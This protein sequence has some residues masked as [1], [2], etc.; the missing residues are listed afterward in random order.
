MVVTSATDRSRS[1]VVNAAPTTRWP[2]LRLGQIWDHR[3]LLWF[4]AV[5]DVKVRYKQALL[6]VAWA[7]LQ[8]LI[9]ALTFTVLFHE[10][11]DIELDDG[12][13]FAFALA[14]YSA[15]TYFAT[16]VAA[17]TN[18]LL[19]NAELLTK[20][21]F[22]RI[23]APLSSL[24]PGLIDL[25]VGATLALG[26]AIAGGDGVTPGGL[27]LVLPGLALLLVTAAGP[28]L[29]LSATVVRYRDVSVVVTFGLQLLLF[30]SPVAYP[31]ELVPGSWRTVLYLN[32]VSGSLGLLRAALV[33]SDLPSAA[34]L[35]CSAA[36]AVAL[37]VA[38]LAHFRRNEREFA[39]II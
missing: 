15:W 20:V 5:R 11:A 22:P 29:V 1:W 38:G 35:G 2:A 18:T 26:V 4:F 31:P 28:V 30:A 36:V 3:E 37:L 33:G 25:A 12:S 21:A 24:L 10:L 9:G 7:G 6:G 8:P 19:Y 16:S 39:D 17:G 23:V 14:G 34:Q 13:Y 27:L 32:P